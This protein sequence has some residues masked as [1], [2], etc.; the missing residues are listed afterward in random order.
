MKK[1]PESNDE[2]KVVKGRFQKGG[3]GGP[4]RP[5]KSDLEKWLSKTFPDLPI[6][7]VKRLAKLLASKSDAT[8]R[9][10]LE[11]IM[12]F[13]PEKP[14]QTKYL[15]PI[16]SDMMN[17]YVGDM[18]G[19]AALMEDSSKRQIDGDYEGTHGES[20]SPEKDGDAATN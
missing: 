15:S 10:G 2:K 20:E 8:F 1:K 14:Q 4:G 9:Q 3:P 17:R 13:S 12:K 11:F 7:L 19:A 16:V 5:K 18:M 6:Q